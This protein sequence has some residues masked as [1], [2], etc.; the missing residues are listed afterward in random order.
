MAAFLYSCAPKAVSTIVGGEYNAQK[1]ETDY[2]VAP[3]G[4]V[5]IPGKWEKTNY[6]QSARQQ[7]F[8]NHDSIIM[9][10]AFGPIDKYEFNANGEKKG[11]DFENAFYQWESKYFQDSHQ[12]KSELV[13][14]DTTANKILFRIHGDIEQGSFDTYFVV[15][16]KDKVSTVL[17]IIKSDKWTPAETID[18]L[19]TIQIK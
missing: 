19:N 5:V 8:A 17:S 3:Y 6:N 14:Q 10:V 4:A 18:F 7:Y 9:S 13:E 16:A 11:F 1:H 15:K 12:L 2:F